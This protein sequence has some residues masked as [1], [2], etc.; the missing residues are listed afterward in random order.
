MGRQQNW[1]KEA[2]LGL[3]VAVQ[4][5]EGVVFASFGGAT[6]SKIVR[7]KA[8]AEILAIVNW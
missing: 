5:R 1:T 6:R 3:M 7:D 2:E 8:W 4:D